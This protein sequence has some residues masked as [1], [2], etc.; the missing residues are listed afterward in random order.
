MNRLVTVIPVYNG[1]RFLQATLESVARQTVR[2]DRLVILDDCSTDGTQALVRGFSGMPCELRQNE[3]RLGLFGNLNR[4]LTFAPECEYLH[5][6]LADDLIAPRFLETLTRALDPV[7]AF[8]LAY[9]LTEFIDAAGQR[10]D[11]P[12]PA[13]RTARQVPLVEFL[14]RQAELQTVSCGSILLK[15]SGRPS[16]VQFRMDMPQTADVVFY[17]EWAAQAPALMEAQEVLCQIRRH[18]YSATA[19]N[20][21]SLQAWVVDEWRTMQLVL[22]LIP[23]SGRARWLRAQRLSCLFAARSYVKIQS[24]RQANPDYARQI[25]EITLQSV[26]PYHW[27]L[28]RLAVAARDALARFGKGA[29]P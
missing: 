25:R 1:E 12:P 13:A 27:L 8:G 18:N 15:T 17:S 14:G 10:L 24:T 3:T 28:G 21:K 22:K 4:C 20:V 29:K 16:P 11:G 19:Q 2:P 5:I 7:P 26:R 23:E 9:C 6:L